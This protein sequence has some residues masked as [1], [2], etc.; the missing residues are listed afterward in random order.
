MTY[1][2][3]KALDQFTF[4]VT[5][6]DITEGSKHGGSFSCPIAFAINRTLGLS[7]VSTMVGNEKPPYINIRIDFRDAKKDE[8]GRFQYFLHSPESRKFV[9]DFDDS[10]EVR[11]ITLTIQREPE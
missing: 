6:E 11:P 7:E 8:P 4:D 1:G 10:I 2:E 5:E 9:E 3:L